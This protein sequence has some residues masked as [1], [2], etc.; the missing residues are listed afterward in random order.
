MPFTH[1]SSGFP[2][3]NIRA[4]P[5]APSSNDHV[6]LLRPISYSIITY[7]FLNLIGPQ[8]PS[9]KAPCDPNWPESQAWHFCWMISALVEMYIFSTSVMITFTHSSSKASSCKRTEIRRISVC[10]CVEETT[11]TKRVHED[12]FKVPL[13]RIGK[14]IFR[15]RQSLPIFGD[16]FQSAAR[17]KGVNVSNYIDK[18]SMK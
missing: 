2:K 16:L 10:G 17:R 3:S 13:F 12:L 7:F 5:R 9:P 6:K 18:K 8:L 1:S 14:W 4:N 11:W 15:N